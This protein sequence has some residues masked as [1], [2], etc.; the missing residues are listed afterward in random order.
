MDMKA[1]PYMQIQNVYDALERVGGE[2]GA[3]YAVGVVLNCVPD[4]QAGILALAECG[5]ESK[6]GREMARRLNLQ[7][8]PPDEPEEDF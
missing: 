7:T 3:E 8:I 4:L 6:A 1:S 5:E 2:Q